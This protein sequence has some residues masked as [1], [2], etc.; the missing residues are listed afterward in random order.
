MKS[1]GQGGADGRARRRATPAS[2]RP[3]A[4]P[5]ARSAAPSAAT[6]A[7]APRSAPRAARPPASWARCSAGCSR[8]SEPDPVYRELRREV[9]ARQRLRADRLA[10]TGSQKH[11]RRSTRRQKCTRTAFRLV[12]CC[13]LSRSASQSNASTSCIGRSNSRDTPSRKRDGFDS[14]MPVARSYMLI[15]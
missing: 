7:R 11:A 3:S 2:A 8:R 6:S 12:P 10:V 4:R 14:T 13:P 15:G 5:A 1:G 9:P